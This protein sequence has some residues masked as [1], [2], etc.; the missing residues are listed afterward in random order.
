MVKVGKENYDAEVLQAETPVI[1]DFWGPG[2]APCLMLMP[3]VEAAAEKYQGRVKFCKLNSAENHRLCINLK[4]LGLP[5][6]LAYKNG[7]EVRRVSGYDVKMEDIVQLAE[8]L[9]LM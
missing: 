8:E 5:A 7:E 2:C 9:L 3:Q 6:F 4:V 1:V